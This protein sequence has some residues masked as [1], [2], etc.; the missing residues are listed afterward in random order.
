MSRSQHRPFLTAYFASAGL[1]KRNLPTRFGHAV[2]HLSATQA[3]TR[4]L[5]A[6]EFAVA[7]VYSAT[8]ARLT[9]VARAGRQ[10]STEGLLP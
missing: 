10:L 1:A 7:V 5:L 6:N 4:R 9:T 8:G 3:A 2:T